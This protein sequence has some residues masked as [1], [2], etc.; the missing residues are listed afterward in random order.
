MRYSFICP[1]NFINGKH[2]W[3]QSDFNLALSHLI[4]LDWE[5]N[6]YTKQLVKAK[7]EYGKSIYLDNWVFENWKPEWIKV[8]IDK[9][10][11]LQSL[12]A[13][14]DYVFVP[15]ELYDAEKTYNNLIEW[16]KEFSL[17]VR[18][19]CKVLSC[20]VIQWNSKKE[21]MDFVMKI[22]NNHNV[23]MIA[24]SY[25]ACVRCFQEETWT[26]NIS[27]NRI[28]ALRY[29]I[30]K[31]FTRI[32]LLWLWDDLSDLKFAK[33]KYPSPTF[34]ITNDSSSAFMTW[35]KGKTYRKNWTINWGKIQEKVNFDLSKITPEQLHRINK[36]IIFIKNL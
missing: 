25:L 12:W 17:K 35:L 1:T 4:N 30:G 11:H 23:D 7:K 28:A 16:N 14:P 34:E 19:R 24:L 5:V 8:V 21:F 31:W 36:N 22:R 33:E 20:V 15:D 32:H 29:I 6:E 10:Y 27:T 18:D 26:Q 2:I 3:K 9:I 13:K